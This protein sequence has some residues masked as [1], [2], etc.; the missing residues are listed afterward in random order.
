[1]DLQVTV[2]LHSCYLVILRR[3]ESRHSNSGCY[4]QM[5]RHVILHNG[6]DWRNR[7]SSIEG[8]HDMYALAI[9]VTGLLEA[10]NV[11]QAISNGCDM[12]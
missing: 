5:E 8:N 9:H 10:G 2:C 7:S 3:T 11:P 12:L 1:M 4:Q 6:V